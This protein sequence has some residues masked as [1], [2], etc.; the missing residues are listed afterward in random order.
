MPAGQ[1]RNLESSDDSPDLVSH[2]SAF[3]LHP[4]LASIFAQALRNLTA[5]K[6]SLSHLTQ[7]F[8][9]ARYVAGR[10]NPRQALPSHVRGGIPV[11]PRRTFAPRLNRA[12]ER[13]R[14]YSVVT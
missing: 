7:K 14:H 4:N 10:Q 12:V 9:E 13:K 5:A 3:D 8:F 1:S 11:Q 6:I 2:L